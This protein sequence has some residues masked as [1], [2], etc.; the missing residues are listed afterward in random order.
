[1]PMIVVLVAMVVKTYMNILAIKP[2]R[3][4]KRSISLVHPVYQLPPIFALI[5]NPKRK[6]ALMVLRLGL[7]RCIG[8]THYALSQELNAMQIVRFI[9]LSFKF[10]EFLASLQSFD[11]IFALVVSAPEC[12]LV[13]SC[14]I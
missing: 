2:T 6:N 12:I 10:R 13:K 8:M 5:L 9:D 4:R 14:E 3:R 1:M 11:C 7:H